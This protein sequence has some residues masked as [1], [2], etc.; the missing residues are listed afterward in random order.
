M[1]KDILFFGDHRESDTPVPIPNTAVK[2]F[3]VDGTTRVALWESRTLP[4][5]I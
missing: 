5:F 1:L 3:I 2:P 4:E